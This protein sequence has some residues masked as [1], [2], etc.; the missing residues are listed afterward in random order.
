MTEAV[1]GVEDDANSRRARRRGTARARPE[2]PPSR[3]GKAST[4]FF[5]IGI[6]LMLGFIFYVGKP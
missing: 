4:T 3:Q 2:L 5:S 6:V 1:E